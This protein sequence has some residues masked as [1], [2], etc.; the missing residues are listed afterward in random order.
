MSG[1]KAIGSLS[2]L[3]STTNN[4]EYVIDVPQSGSCENYE[5]MITS[6]TGSDTLYVYFSSA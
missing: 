2:S 1:K 6:G 3:E 4:T 5:S